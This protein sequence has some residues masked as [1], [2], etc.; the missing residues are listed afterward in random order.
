MTSEDAEAC[1][2]VTAHTHL[3]GPF[4]LGR[5]SAQNNFRKE[6]RR[7]RSAPARPPVNRHHLDEFSSQQDLLSHRDV[8]RQSTE[9]GPLG[10]PRRSTTAA[11]PRP[12]KEPLSIRPMLLSNFLADGLHIYVHH[13]RHP[14]QIPGSDII[15]R[16]Y[17]MGV[18][19]VL[20]IAM[21]IIQQAIGLLVIV[22]NHTRIGAHYYGLFFDDQIALFDETDYVDPDGN[23]EAVRQLEDQEPKLRPTFN[24]HVANLLL[25][26]SSMAYQRD[27]K[28]VAEAAKILLDVKNQAQR[29]K[30]AKLLEESE[31]VID[32]NAR[33]EFGMRF[34]GISELKTLGG[35]FAGL[36]YNDDAIVLVFKGTSVLAFNEYLIDVTIQRVDASEY[37]F[38]EVHKGFYESLFPDAKPI[39]EYETRTYDQ[40]NPF[41]TIME[42]IFETA[43]ISKQ[44]TGKPVNLWLTG[45]SL[46]GALAAMTMARLQM[47]VREGDPLTQDDEFIPVGDNYV[48]A[49]LSQ[50]ALP[51]TVLQEMLARFSDDQELIHLRDCYS[52]ASPKL[53]DSEF[54]KEFAQNQL[55]FSTQSPYKTTYWR[56]VADK[57]I[58]PHMPPGINVNPKKPND[59]IFP[60]RFCEP[61]P[62]PWLNREQE[63]HG[64]ANIS[65]PHSRNDSSETLC[66]L[67]EVQEPPKAKKPSNQPPPPPPPKHLHSLLD[68]QH[69]G[70]LVKVCHKP[71]A[72]TVGPSAFEPD[73]S[74]GVLRKKGETDGLLLKLAKITAMSK[75]RCREDDS[76]ESPRKAAAPITPS[77]SFSDASTTATVSSTAEAESLK[78]LEAVTAEQ[79]ASDMTKAQAL[80][81]V[82]ELSR[83]RQ[84]TL[85]EQILLS[86]PSLL[87]HAPAAYQRN[88]VRARFHFK[89]FPGAAFEKR[90][91]QWLEEAC[92]RQEVTTVKVTKGHRNGEVIMRHPSNQGLQQEEQQQQQQRRQ[93][94]QQYDAHGSTEYSEEVQ[95]ELAVDVDTH[96]R[97][98]REVRRTVSRKEYQALHTET[99]VAQTASL[100]PREE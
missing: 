18:L 22:V 80:Y 57:D 95:V 46:G 20:I 76:N 36:F 30:A 73:L 3:K 92:A 2:H 98:R 4:A 6:D 37:L 10:R 15:S 7:K 96:V 16:I 77:S 9:A 81:D 82:D 13:L 11:A 88:L 100:R 17:A 90:V 34:M 42:T 63:Q 61:R 24:Y 27:D 45:H 1:V 59:R 71:K 69:V 21:T 40:T 25:I 53:G 43:R 58:V 83:L 60:C 74:E 19:P 32:E 38:G 33:R 72:P 66:S 44:K 64:L 91:G 67:Q 47:P 75:A 28:L 41:N 50:G 86:I 35:P 62:N 93:P 56:M 65:L 31:R 87:S 39:S 5:S 84:P 49:P 29:E 52:I 99:T 48:R 54:A 23:D 97:S 85:L 12:L 89:S 55:H 26:M 78:Q 70:Q 68:Y 51:R 8:K 94:Q 14:S 79:V